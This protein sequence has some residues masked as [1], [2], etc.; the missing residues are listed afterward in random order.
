MSRAKHWC[1]T[2]NNYTDEDIHKL[3]KASLLLQPLVSSCIYQQ[4]VPGQ[5]SATP[6]TPH[7]QGFISFKTKQSFKFT[8]NLVSDRA[9]VEVAKGTPQ[10][11]R[12]YC[13]KAKDRKIGTEVFTYGEQPKLLP[14]KR[15]D[16]YAFQQYVKEGN[17]Q[18]RD[19]L[20]N[21]AS[22]AARY[23][24]YVREYI[25][26][27]VN[28]PEVPDHPLYLWQETLTKIITGPSDDRQIIFVVDEVG[29][30]GKT[31]FAKKYCRA[32][33]DA[34]F[35]EPGKKADMA[36]ALNTDLRV[37]FL[38]VTRQQ[39]EHLQYSFLEAVK[40]GSVW[41]PKYESRTKH[42]TQIPHIVVMMNQDP[43]FQLLSKD[44]YHTIYI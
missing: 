1:F 42:L 28:P 9:H 4:E 23:P 39:V 2:V 44:R 34:Q 18:T 35:L 25:D 17:I 30:Q 36:Y 22:V 16:L 13:S 38:N 10:Q 27:Y 21:H 41:S 6:G 37:L 20:E 14:G 15:N 3:S 29:N 32:H 24:R 31:W 8:K 33:E 5:E 19:I 40:D 11:N 12:I 26:L 43:D 7:L